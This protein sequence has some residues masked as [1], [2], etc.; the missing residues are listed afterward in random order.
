MRTRC[1]ACSTV[2][3]VTS[4]Q[5]RLKAGKVRCGH[6][7]AVF[8]AFD[9]FLP[10]DHSPESRSQPAAS[11]VES[12]EPAPE[13]WP[14]IMIPEPD[15]LQEGTS[16]V[17]EELP[18]E[19]AD[20]PFAA[21]SLPELPVDPDTAPA[22]PPADRLD[23]WVAEA[24]VADDFLPTDSPTATEL[25]PEEWRSDEIDLDSGPLTEPPLE[26]QEE[27]HEESTQ[28]ARQAGL[29]AARELTESPAYNRWAADAL[30]DGGASSFAP[31]PARRLVWPF[32]VVALL[33][34]LGLL[35]Q[36]LLHF[37]SDVVRWLP[38]AAS[39]YQEA[40]ISVPL[41]RNP[42]LVVIEASDL[43]ADNARGMFVL[44]ATLHNRANYAQDW[45]A[46]ELTLTDA[47]DS[48]VARRVMSAAEY[49]PPAIS[50]EVFPANGEV[51][52]RLW[53]EA[54]NLGAAGYRLYVFYP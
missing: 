37:R 21:F 2:F 31:P 33:L 17:R 26:T 22:E 46:L 39:Y 25:P 23:E 6:C 43:Q 3:R 51:A 24:L 8:N 49:L 18:A 1:P 13:A 19:P 45:P 11:V 9:E 14:P 12:R 10:E 27:T 20:L 15:A 41:P 7:Q 52:V 32:V 53:I 30:A 5:L 48:V 34:A 40:G 28:A 50:P 29:V 38:A 44:Q 47:S 54:R 35:V 36:L 16:S 4:E 42:D